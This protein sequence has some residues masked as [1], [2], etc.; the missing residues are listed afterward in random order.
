MKATA[1][2]SI[3]KASPSSGQVEISLGSLEKK[4]N[5]IILGQ[6]ERKRSQRGSYEDVVNS[7]K[8]EEFKGPQDLISEVLIPP[9]NP[10]NPSETYQ[11]PNKPRSQFEGNSR[12]Q[13]SGFDRSTRVQSPQKNIGGT[14]ILSLETGQIYHW[15]D[16]RRDFKKI[17][18]LFYLTG[19]FSLILT[20]KRLRQ[21]VQ[22]GR[23]LAQPSSQIQ[24]DEPRC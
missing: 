1:P 2:A 6:S 20:L 19:K 7:D 23:K 22:G 12:L 17:C 10:S 13:A 15:T 5:E 14:Q 9:L 4:A 16:I 18:G 24:A 21:S 11:T 8:S 3:Q